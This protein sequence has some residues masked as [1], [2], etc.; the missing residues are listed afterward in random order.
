MPEVRVPT[1]A[2]DGDA[3]C[4]VSMWFYPTGTL[5][6]QGALLGELMVDKATVEV[7][8]PAA[9]RFVIVVPLD[10]VAK[11]GAVLATVE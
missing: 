4:T 6:A 7:H 2:W 1:N 8:A 3:E 10:G 9:G 5:V 11:K